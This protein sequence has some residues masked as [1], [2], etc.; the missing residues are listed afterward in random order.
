MES[1]KEALIGLSATAL[2]TALQHLTEGGE[3]DLKEFTLEVSKDAYEIEASSAPLEK[4]RQ[5]RQ[6]LLEQA[7]MKAEKRRIL[8]EWTLWPLF[9]SIVKGIT[10]GVFGAA[11][12]AL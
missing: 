12:I 11:K 7:R 9:T 3:A 4:K 5:M 10:L 6:Q 2:T 8:T 1:H